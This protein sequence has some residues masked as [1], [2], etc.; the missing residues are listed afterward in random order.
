MKDL[1]ETYVI[2]GIK[3]TKTK[4]SVSPKQSHYIEK[5]LNNLINLVVLQ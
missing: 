4:E 1:G 2:L 3:M 5:I